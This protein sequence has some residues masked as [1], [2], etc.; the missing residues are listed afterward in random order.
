MSR[1]SQTDS[2]TKADVGEE[3]DFSPTSKAE[4]MA[5]G[6]DLRT[7]KPVGGTP[8]PSKLMTGDPDKD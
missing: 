3:I 4:Q 2:R 1:D 7:T 8:A 5:M 6:G